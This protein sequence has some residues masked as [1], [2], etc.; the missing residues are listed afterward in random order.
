MRVCAMTVVDGGVPGMGT[1]NG[2]AHTCIVLEHAHPAGGLKAA[3][4]GGERAAGEPLP[5]GEWIAAR[6]MGCVLDDGGC[7]EGAPHGHAETCVGIASDEAA[8][9]RAVN[10]GG[11]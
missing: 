4:G 6:I 5:R 7:S 11:G 3:D 1:C 9:G 8:H 10:R 2:I